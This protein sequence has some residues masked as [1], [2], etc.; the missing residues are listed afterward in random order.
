MAILDEHFA[1]L[2][3]IAGRRFSEATRTEGSNGTWVVKLCDFVLPPGWNRTHT[4]VYFLV[5]AGY[6]VA[7]PDTFW[8]DRGLQLASGGPPA[9]TGSNQPPGVPPDL[10]WFSWHPAAWNPNRDNLVNYVVMI[11]RRFEEKR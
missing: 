8:T 10:L 1:Q 2:E 3:S 4:N 7:R 11:R 9:S 6:P 5:P